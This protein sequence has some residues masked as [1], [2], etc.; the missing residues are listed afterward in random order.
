MS[1]FSCLKS[2]VVAEKLI[3]N[4]W[5][6]MARFARSGGYG[7]AI[8]IRIIWDV[9]KIFSRQYAVIMDGMTGTCQ[10]T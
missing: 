3:W 10:P 9:V 5:A 2:E 4:K 8:A 1:T 6:D 7:N